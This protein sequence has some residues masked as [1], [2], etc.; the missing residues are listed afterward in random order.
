MLSSH[1]QEDEQ[2]VKPYK[3]DKNADYSISWIGSAFKTAD[4]FN[5]T[6]NIFKE[7]ID[8]HWKGYKG[9]RFDHMS[10]KKK[11]M[12]EKSFSLTDKKSVEAFRIIAQ[13]G[14]LCDDGENGYIGQG[15]TTDVLIRSKGKEKTKHMYYF[16]IESN[17][18]LAKMMRDLPQ[19]I[20]AALGDGKARLNP[21]PLK[22]SVHKL[23]TAI[24]RYQKVADS[25]TAAYENKQPLPARELTTLL[26]NPTLK[27]VLGSRAAE[28]ETKVL[29]T[30]A[31]G[32]MRAFLSNGSWKAITGNKPSP[33]AF[34]IELKDIRLTETFGESAILP[35]QM[36][37][38]DTHMPATLISQ[39]GRDLLLTFIIGSRYEQTHDKYSE[40]V[41]DAYSLGVD[42]N[43]KLTVIARSR[44]SEI[45]DKPA[46]AFLKE[47]EVIARLD[48]LN[49]KG[50]I[51]VLFPRR[52]KTS[53]IPPITLTLETIS[54]S[55]KHEGLAK[56][57]FFEGYDWKI[58]GVYKIKGE[59]QVGKIWDYHKYHSK[60]DAFTS[61]EVFRDKDGNIAK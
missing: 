22:R 19:R 37:L 21:Q 61:G 39:D 25:L 43:E 31:Q 6:A 28:K 38:A 33:Q 18:P 8:I 24:M 13:Y 5:V 50:I 53:K 46:L 45:D 17:E 15:V 47:L 57:S 7:K 58:L 49:E 36:N 14:E 41:R 51:D 35:F 60:K 12:F 48:Y 30:E 40:R 2:E 4:A 27:E 59:W 34:L 32:I 23:S 26:R 55:E 56:I 3:L 54:I 9:G 1:A 20:K 11:A 29:A 42:K 44:H 16:V 10:D 52:D